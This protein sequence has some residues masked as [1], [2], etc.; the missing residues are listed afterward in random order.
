MEKFGYSGL[1]PKAGFYHQNGTGR[2]SYIGV[3]H[4][5]LYPP[6]VARNEYPTSQFRGKRHAIPVT[7]TSSYKQ[8]RYKSNGTGRDGYIHDSHGGFETNGYIHS[9]KNTFYRSLRDN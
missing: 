6:N 1:D 3:N 8:C 9:A 2:D 4:G 5:G 7:T